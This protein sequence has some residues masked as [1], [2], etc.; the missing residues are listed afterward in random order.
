MH[1]PGTLFSRLIILIIYPGRLFSLPGI[2]FTELLFISCR[3]CSISLI[4]IIH[5]LLYIRILQ[6]HWMIPL[7][8]FVSLTL[9]LRDHRASLVRFSYRLYFYFLRLSYSLFSFFN[10]IIFLFFS[11][12]V[13]LFSFSSQLYILFKSIFYTTPV[14]LL[15]YLG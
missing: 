15:L 2:F 5:I 3:F 6:I 11:T 8:G 12:S 9:F 14:F 4:Y 7:S 10:F 1:N 13:F